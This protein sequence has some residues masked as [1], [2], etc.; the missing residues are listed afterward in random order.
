MK[1]R[2]CRVC[3][4]QLTKE[5]CFW[6]AKTKA[7]LCK[8]C[9]LEDSKRRRITLK[10]SVVKAYGGA[11]VCCNEHRPEFMTI[12]HKTG[13]RDK[14]I[15]NYGYKIGGHTLYA[16]LVSNGFPTDEYQLMCWNCNCAKRTYNTCPH[17]EPHIIKGIEVNFPNPYKSA[18]KQCTNCGVAL[19][20]VGFTNT[21]ER[22]VKNRSYVCRECETQKVLHHNYKSKLSLI[23]AYD[24]SCV[25]CGEDNPFFLTID[26][27]AN[28]GAK[29]RRNSGIFSGTS[30]YQWLKRNG[31]P[32][33]N[34]QLLCFNCND[35]KAYY[36]Y[37]PH[38]RNV[39]RVF[40]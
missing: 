32:K 1:I 11:C 3:K 20:L 16:F 13:N 21:C 31:Y 26:H 25:C 29:H 22:W 4:V 37:C 12:D 10:T 28:D 7:Y 23:E 9:D 36:G 38:Q 33:D 19:D 14:E 5:N 35:S 34:F 18:N 40:V 8:T 27:I 2:Y 6:S 24:G 15:E 30:M 39:K 17:I